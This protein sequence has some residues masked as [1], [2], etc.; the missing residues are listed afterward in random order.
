VRIVIT[1]RHNNPLKIQKINPLLL[2]VTVFTALLTSCSPN[3]QLKNSEEFNGERAYQDIKVQVDLGPRVPGSDAN[4]QIGEWLVSELKD[5]GW[6]VNIQT[7][8]ILGHE[9]VNIIAD[10]RRNS[11]RPWIILG[12][13]YDTRSV[14][15]RDNQIDNQ[16]N[17]IPGAND[18]AS[19]VSVLMEL[20][21]ILPQELELNI[22]LAFFDAEDQGKLPTWDWSLGASAYVETLNDHPDSVVIVDM[23]GD[24]NLDIYIEKNSDQELAAE[25]WDTAAELGYEEFNNFPKYSIVDDHR[26]FVQAG[27]P[28]ILIIDFEYP[29]WHTTA[30]TVDKVSPESLKAVGDVLLTWIYSLSD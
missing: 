1:L 25:I 17:P 11:D 28:A 13:H 7:D 8:E 30:D 2:A 18:G 5:N 24:T 27:I 3:Q 15:D 16:D 21:R 23:V 20:A 22:S 9:V 10:R 4:R 26:P 6:D 14:A 29:Y 19:G 12:A